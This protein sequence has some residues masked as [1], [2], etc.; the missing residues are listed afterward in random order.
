MNSERV[1][2]NYGVPQRSINGPL[3]NI[4]FVND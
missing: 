2:L 1:Y 4:L 3:L